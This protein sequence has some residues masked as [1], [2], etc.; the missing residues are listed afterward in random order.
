MQLVRRKSNTRLI[1]SVDFIPALRIR[2]ATPSRSGVAMFV[3]SSQ[4]RI[5]ENRLSAFNCLVGSLSRKYNEMPWYM[6]DLNLQQEH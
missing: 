4:L 1:V 2:R 6:P 3:I 5:G